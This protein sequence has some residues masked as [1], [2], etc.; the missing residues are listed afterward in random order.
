MEKAL[1]VL[2]PA[3]LI[4]SN[5]VCVFALK[6]SVQICVQLNRAD[7]VSTNACSFGGSEA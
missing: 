4:Q 3:L 2:R 5:S 6:C 7:C 1:T